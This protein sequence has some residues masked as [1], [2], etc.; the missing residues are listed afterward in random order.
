MFEFSSRSL[1]LL[2]TVHPDLVRVAK[3]A[4]KLS[5]M[6]F[7]VT[8]GA[9]SYAEQVELVKTGA[10]HDLHSLHVL[11]EDGYAH[12][13]DVAAWFNGRISWNNA[14]YGPIVQAFIEASNSLEIQ[15]EFG[16]LWPRFQDS[17]HI[18]LNPKYHKSV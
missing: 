14:H 12:A 13:I 10:S 8:C 18:Q 6:D 4:I 2:G 11:Q 15:L 7:G 17:V 5:K 3:K 9:R 16:H 1:C